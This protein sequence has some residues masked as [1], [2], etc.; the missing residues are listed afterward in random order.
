[1]DNKVNWPDDWIQDLID[2]PPDHRHFE[3]LFLQETYLLESE[4]LG[5]ENKVH[6]ED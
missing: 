1:M 3:Q 5:D 4:I 6:I 2:N